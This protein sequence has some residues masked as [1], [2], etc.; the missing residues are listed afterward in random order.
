MQIYFTNTLWKQFYILRSKLNRGICLQLLLLLILTAISK[1]TIAQ[2]DKHVTFGIKEESL[3]HA[4][5]QLAKVSGVNIV[6]PSLE[7]GKYK[8]INLPT[9][10]RSLSK[11]LELLLKNTTLDFKFINDRIVVFKKQAIKLQVTH[12]PNL[13]D[14]EGVVVDEN[15][16]PLSNISVIAEDKSAGAI[17]NSNGRFA[18]K[19]IEADSPLK[20]GGIGYQEITAK[21]QRTLE[22]TLSQV[23]GTM[24]EVTVN[25]G[26]QTLPKER[27]TGSF[28]LIGNQLIN[29]SVTTNILDRLENLTPGFLFNHGDAINT[30]LMLIRGR[31]TIFADASPL[32]VVDNFP[33]DGDI[34]NINPNDVES[35]S[36][37]KDAAA[38]S[39]WGARAGNGVIV[40]VTKKGKSSKPSVEL[41]SNINFMQ[42]PDLFN[43]NMMSGADYAELEKFL[44][45]KGFYS[46]ASTVTPVVELLQ[47]RDSGFISDAEAGARIDALKN[48][49]VRNDLQQYFYRKGLNQQYALNVGGNTPN[50]NY[51]FSAGYDRNIATLAGTNSHRITL[52]TQNNFRVTKNLDISAGINF[53]QNQSDKG[54]NSGYR[55]NRNSKLLYPYAQLANANGNSLP[56]YMNYTKSFIESAKAKGLLGWDWSPLED[57]GYTDYQSKIR[58]YTINTT[59]KYRITNWLSIEAKYQYENALTFGSN[60]YMEQSYYTRNY[61]NNF[62]Q[63]NATTGVLTYPVPKG[64][65]VDYQNAE[66]NSHQGR[67]QLNFNKGWSNMRHQLNGVAGWEIRSNISAG[68]NYRLYGYNPETS[69]GVSNLDYVTAFPQYYS[70]S[71]TSIIVNSTKVSKTTDNFL[72]YYA[73]TAYTYNRKYILSGSVRKDEANLF[74]VATN[75]KGAPFWSIGGA[76]QLSNEEFYKPKW[77]PLLKLRATYGYNGN[78]SRLA[79]AETVLTYSY[80]I[81]TPYRSATI[82]NPPNDQLRW[83]RTGQINIGI[84][85]AIKNDILA[86]TIEYYHKRSKDLFGQAPIDPTIGL[87]DNSGNNYFFGNVAGMKGNGVDIQLDAKAGRR[88]FVWNAHLVFSHVIS[89]VTEYLMPV[90]SSGSDYLSIDAFSIN[91]VVGRPVFSMYS[92]KW[93]GLDHETGDPIGFYSGGKSKDYRNIFLNTPLDSMVYSGSAV[94]TSFGALMNTFSYKNLSISFNISYKFGYYFRRPSVSYTSIYNGQSYN[95][96]YALRWQQPGDEITTTVPSLMYPANSARDAFYLNSEILVEK[97]DNIRLEDIRLNY[98]LN[99]NQVRYSPFKQARIFIYVSNIG[100]LWK[101]SEIDQYYNNLPRAG[102]SVALGINLQ[103]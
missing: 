58:D 26:Y 40:I 34:T 30:D 35:V 86:G 55:T 59:I 63:V 28:D 2:G 16:Q 38:A 71:G 101:T 31:S 89:K 93:E 79:S 13:I 5:D 65:I 24:D 98:Q 97:G 3:N 8:R 54:E 57:I 80:A 19:G 47:Q 76:W 73:N 67:T 49:D 25:T 95:R 22:I 88:N 78:I 4:L 81:K 62:T 42:R 74:G 91:P 66:L 56:I 1:T 99:Q 43:I 82:T 75:Q 68:N 52:R 53:V 48:Y 72:S 61:I 69:T 96:D 84:D 18:I 102:R 87:V 39:I 14:V 29:R 70:L 77:L 12:T 10:S 51:Y 50:L 64:G 20:I 7:T 36:I 90:S 100:T 37:L 9:A 85:F 60:Y 103:L 33:Y 94:P 6:Y 44:Y 92:Y 27:S 46:N 21:A 23:I 32:I 17:T 41:T 11:T 83:E 45:S 15:G